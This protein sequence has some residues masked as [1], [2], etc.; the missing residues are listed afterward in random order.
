MLHQGERTTLCRDDTTLLEGAE[1][2]LEVWLLEERLGW[3]LWVG[4]VG[5]DDIELV[6]VVVEELES[7]ADV[8]L[9]LRVLVADGHAREV[10]LGETDDSLRG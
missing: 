7:V 9:D 10:L 1:E 5:D 2:E 4:G 8:D 3:S 6:L